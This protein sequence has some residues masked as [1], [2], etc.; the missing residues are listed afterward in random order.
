M[1]LVDTYVKM[2]TNCMRY[3]TNGCSPCLL[4]KNE[5][6]TELVMVIT[7]FNCYQLYCHTGKTMH[8]FRALK[9]PKKNVGTCMRMWMWSS[10]NG[11]NGLRFTLVYVTCGS[12]FSTEVVSVVIVRTVV[13][14]RLT[15]A[16]AD[17]ASMK[18]DSQDM[19]TSR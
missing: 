17:L 9:N 13:T 5:S 3:S 6:T 10:S 14:P 1:Y 7:S 2:N 19:M 12:E 16:G 15:L 11:G 4:S 8:M 18:N